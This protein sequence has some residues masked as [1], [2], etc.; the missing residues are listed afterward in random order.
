MSIRPRLPVLFACA[1]AVACAANDSGTAVPAFSSPDAAPNDRRRARRRHG[2]PRADVRH[3]PGDGARRDRGL[4]RRRA[5]TTRPT[6]P[7][8][9]DRRRRRRRRRRRPRGQR[10]AHRR[11]ACGRRPRARVCAERGHWATG[12]TTTARARRRGCG[13]LRARRSPA[14]TAPAERGRGVCGT[15][16]SAAR[17][18]GVRHVERVRGLEQPRPS[19]AAWG[20]TSTA[21]AIDGAAPAS[22]GNDAPLLLGAAWAPRAS[23]PAA[24][25]RRR[26]GWWAR[27]PSGDVRRRGAPGAARHLRRRR[28]RLRR[29]PH[30]GCACMIPDPRLLHQMPRR[31]AAVGSPRRHPDLRGGRRRRRGGVG[32]SAP[33]DAPATDR[34]VTASTATATATPTPAAAGMMG[35]TRVLQARRAPGVGACR[36]GTQTCVARPCRRL[37]LG[38]V[39]GQVIPT[40]DRLRRRRPQLRRQPQHG[41]RVHHRDDAGLLHGPAGTQGVGICRAGFQACA[42]WHHRRGARAWTR[43]RPRRPLR[44][45]RPQLRRQPQHW[46]RARSGRRAR[47]ATPG[48]A[49]HQ[50]SGRC[51][52]ARRVASRRRG[53]R[54]PVGEGG[55]RRR[56]A[57]RRR[58]RRAATASTTTATGWSMRAAR[59]CP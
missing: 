13:S 14:T 12:P 40:A 21:T 57:P 55:V 5:L 27:A 7:T 18:R 38:R 49:G 32:A 45:R 48:P 6:R 41:L 43:S 51:R 46:L 39:H 20:W 34:C 59:V 8:A 25:A 33:P 16:R 35:A 56:D 50:A 42:A 1:T 36:A 10:S 11:R 2:R 31:H 9:R 19:C 15:G 54:T 26:A 23:A 44:Q 30:T 4:R 24:A 58:W 53:R 22:P 3:T 52:A 47:P 17:R 28:P 29:Q 37:G